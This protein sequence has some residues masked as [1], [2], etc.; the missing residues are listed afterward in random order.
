MP[1]T[2]VIMYNND[3]GF[4]KLVLYLQ[5]RKRMIEQTNPKLSKRIII[6]IILLIIALLSIFLVSKLVTAPEFNA[7]TIKSL[8]DKKVTVMK[9]AVS[10]AASS[11]A[12]SLLPGDIATPIA[13]EI[14]EITSY[15]IIILGAI[16]LEKILI[17][18]VGYVSFTYII[19]I[20]CLLGIAYLFLKNDV[21]KNLAIKL[22]IFGVVIFVT[23]PVSIHVSDLIYNSYQS[24]IEETIQTAQQNKEEID[25]KKQ[26]FANEDKN[27]MEKIESYLSNVTSKIGS[28]ITSIVKKGEDM[29]ASFLNA[30][31][32]LIIISCVIPA[33]VIIIFAFVIKIL[34]GFDSS[35]M[36]TAFKEKSK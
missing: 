9:L 33:V 28:D 26:D 16:L 30:I 10:A 11:T 18:V 35:K 15:F 7:A 29:L 27:W 23:I 24:S 34:F 20:A 1:F 2:S 21:F 12:L 17:S 3:N 36:I 31:A 4:A 6:T 19:P 13:N 32:A 22:A 14:A 8:D 5:R 25:E